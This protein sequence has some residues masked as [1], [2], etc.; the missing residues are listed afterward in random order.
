MNMGGSPCGY[1]KS[2]KVAEMIAEVFL[3][4]YSFPWNEIKF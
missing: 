3:L 1:E 2:Q 4:F